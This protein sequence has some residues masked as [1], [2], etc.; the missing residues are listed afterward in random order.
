[1]IIGGALILFAVLLARDILSQKPYALNAMCIN[2][3]GYRLSL[4][5]DP[6]DPDSI[7]KGFAEYAGIDAGSYNVSVDTAVTLSLDLMTDIDLATSEKIFAQ[8]AAS[9]LDA[10]TADEVLFHRYADAEMYMDLREA[11]DPAELERL[12]GEGLVYYVDRAEMEARAAADEAGRG[13]SFV[14]HQT[15]PMEDPVP[16]GLIVASGDG[17]PEAVAGIVVN[18]ERLDNAVAFLRYIVIK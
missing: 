5:G 10:M 8:V 11:M 12:A 1:M 15:Y 2:S 13:G 17:G 14:W 4:P 3:A 16:V 18:T 9:D 6:G 7:A